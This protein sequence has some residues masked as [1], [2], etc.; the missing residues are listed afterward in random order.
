MRFFLIAE[1]RL[2]PVYSI[3]IGRVIGN[4]H[5]DNDDGEKPTDH[6]AVADFVSKDLG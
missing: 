4:R 5:K 6:K 2:T 1:E 3:A